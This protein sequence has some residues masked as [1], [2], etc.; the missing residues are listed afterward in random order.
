MR[1]KE[2]PLFLKRFLLDEQKSWVV[3]LF[4]ISVGFCE[5]HSFVT[6]KEVVLT[7][8]GRQVVYLCFNQKMVAAFFDAVIYIYICIICY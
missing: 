2:F 3:G 8:L 7:Y 4:L 1:L 5:P 6:S